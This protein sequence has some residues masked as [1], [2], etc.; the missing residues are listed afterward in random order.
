MTDCRHGRRARAAHSSAYTAGI[1]GPGSPAARPA[2]AGTQS[3]SGGAAHTTSSGPED[4]ATRSSACC[5]ARGSCAPDDPGVDERDQEQRTG[6]GRDEGPALPPR[7]R[8][9]PAGQPS[10]KQSGE[11]QRERSSE[12]RGQVPSGGRE[13]RQQLAARE[14]VQRRN[15]A[16]SAEA[17]RGPRQEREAAEAVGP[18]AGQPPAGQQDGRAR[19]PDRHGQQRLSDEAGAEQQ[20]RGEGRR[21]G[22]VAEH[23]RR[24][25]QHEAEAEAGLPRAPE[26]EP[27]EPLRGHEARER[28]E[29]GRRGW[30]PC[31]LE[32]EEPQQQSRDGGDEDEQHG[33][34]RVGA[35]ERG[36]SAASEAR[37]GACAPKGAS[38]S[39]GSAVSG[40]PSRQSSRRAEVV[41]KAMP[42]PG[43]CWKRGVGATQREPR[44][45]GSCP[46]LRSRDVAWRA[47]VWARIR[48]RPVASSPAAAG[49]SCFGKA[50]SS[51][52]SAERRRITATT[53]PR[54][55]PENTGHQ[56]DRAQKASDSAGTTVQGARTTSSPGSSSKAPS[57]IRVTVT[58][59]DGTTIL[60]GSARVTIALHDPGPSRLRGVL[61]DWDGTL[62]DSAEKSFRCYARVFADYGISYDTALFERTY[63]PDW[64]RT[65]EAIGL[66]REVWTEA[67][68]RWLECYESEP[69]R[70]LPGAREALAQLAGRGLVQGLVSSGDPRRVRREVAKHGVAHFFPVVVCGGETVEMHSR[71]WR[72]GPRLSAW[73]RSRP[74]TIPLTSRAT[75]YHPLVRIYRRCPRPLPRSRRRSRRPVRP[76]IACARSW[77]KEDG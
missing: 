18:P 8:R 75:C 36:L 48:E 74:K 4:P 72:T 23:E 26:R 76:R 12:E 67:D 10:G 19:R 55:R 3:R 27:I 39:S 17:R 64:Y 2:S 30:E 21:P 68:A 40:T 50:R 34:R 24:A 58:S 60:R 16:G 13:D 20:A 56:S 65:Y 25:G 1:Q 51:R 38:G 15:E 7:P 71:M 61:F 5:P 47:R 44:R 14:R 54:A 59:S 70:L 46:L 77:S 41:W 37:A 22:D 52:V 42:G 11:Q 63:A 6:R 53:R 49:V 28:A 35:R 29:R 66:P 31:R 43:A 9:E 32:C 57:T 62:V 73:P 45:P 33:A 69:S